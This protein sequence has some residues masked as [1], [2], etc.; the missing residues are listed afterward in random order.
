MGRR[1]GLVW[2]CTGRSI[3]DMGEMSYLPQ[4]FWQELLLGLVTVLVTLIGLLILVSPILGSL[5]QVS[6]RVVGEA[7]PGAAA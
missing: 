2:F 6:Q 1:K 4:Q 5:S 3:L 7:S